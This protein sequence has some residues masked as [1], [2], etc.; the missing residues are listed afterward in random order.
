MGAESASETVEIRQETLFRQ[1]SEWGMR[2]F[3]G[4]FPRLKDRFIY[5]ERGERKLMLWATVLMFNL[6]T[7]LVGLNQI[8]STYM[9]NFSIEANM[10]MRNEFGI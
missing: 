8:L 7:R 1:A 4:S 6:R 5:E 2:G 10:F 3:Q 9:P